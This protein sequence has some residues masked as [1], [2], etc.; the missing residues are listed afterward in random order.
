MRSRMV[1][2]VSAVIAAAPLAIAGGPWDKYTSFYVSPEPPASQPAKNGA[3]KS[4][5]KADM[6]KKAAVPQDAKK[7]T[8]KPPMPKK[9]EPADE[10]D[11]R[12]VSDFYQIREANPSVTKGEWELEFEYEYETHNHH[13]D[14]SLF[15]ASLKYG[16]TN[17]TFVELEVLPINIGDG[18]DQGAGDLSVILFQQLFREEGARPA[19]A[20]WAEMR[21]PSGDGSSGVDGALHFNLTKTLFP[22]FRAH[23]EG[24]IETVNGTRGGEDEE[25]RPFQWGV[26]PGFDYQFDEKTLG[27]VNYLN[28]C[29]DEEGKPNSNVIEFGVARELVEGQHIKAAVDIG[30]DGHE[31]TPNF[32]AKLLWSIEWK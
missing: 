2:A 4:G 19:A 10:D 7:E 16:L 14:D 30:L 3:T 26:G 9:E 5:E 24:F 23:L 6:G 13:D 27:L 21:V 29:S 1:L 8:A 31:D 22:K 28:R 20:V 18:G 25:Y 11:Y 17:S 32:A 15:S 12:E